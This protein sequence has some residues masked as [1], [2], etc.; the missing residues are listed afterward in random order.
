MNF[1]LLAD[2]RLSMQ[3]PV[4]EIEIMFDILTEKYRLSLNSKKEKIIIFNNMKRK[5]RSCEESK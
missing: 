3:S 1:L 4:E 2:N 5:T